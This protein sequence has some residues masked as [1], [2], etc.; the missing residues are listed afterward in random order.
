[1]L[2][3]ENIVIM[4]K[5]CYNLNELVFYTFIGVIPKKATS[6][7]NAGVALLFC[8]FFTSTKH[9][10]MGYFIFAHVSSFIEIK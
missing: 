10:F 6:P 1:M 3:R 5:M 9:G 2:V 4:A 8:Y 7:A